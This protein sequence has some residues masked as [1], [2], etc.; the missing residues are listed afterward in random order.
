[1][2]L[3]LNGNYIDVS[4]IED[5]PLDLYKIIVKSGHGEYTV[6]KVSEKTLIKLYDDMGKLLGVF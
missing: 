5:T 2:K 3:F 4:K 1:M 6:I